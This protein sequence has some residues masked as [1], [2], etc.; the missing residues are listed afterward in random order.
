MRPVVQSSATTGATAW[1]PVDSNQV[2]FNVGVGVK[3]SSTGTYGV[4]YT[5]DDVFDSTVTPIAFVSTGIPA[6]T[7]VNAA[8]SFTTPC[9]A[10]RLNIAA[11]AG[12]ITM[13]AIQGIGG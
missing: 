9:R 4:E 13:T 7:T 8:M 1:I 2:P 12:T 11:N 3:L 5:F 10:I 6:G